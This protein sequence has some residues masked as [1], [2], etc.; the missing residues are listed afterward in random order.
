MTDPKKTIGYLTAAVFVVYALTSRIPLPCYACDSGSFWYRCIGG[1]GKGTQSCEAFKAAES[2]V[3]LASDIF[4]KAGTFLENAFDFTAVGLPDIITDFIATLKDQ[5]L[6]LKD[7]MSEKISQIINFL[8]E[9]IGL[10]LSKVKEIAVSSYDRYLKKVIDA[11]VSFTVNKLINPIVNI[12]TKIIEFR[13]LVFEKLA[14]A[15]QRFADI[16]IFGFV[17]EVVD[18]FK[19]IPQAIEGLKVNVVNMINGVKNTVIK[20]LNDGINNSAELV[21]DVVDRVS[22]LTDNI[23]DGSENIVNKVIDKIN[24]AMNGVEGAVDGITGGIETAVNN[25]VKPVVNGLSGAVNRARDVSLPL[26]IGK[27]L[28]FLPRMGTFNG[29]NIPDLDIPDISDLK[30]KDVNFSIDIPEVNI[31]APPDINPDNINFPTIPGFGFITDKIQGIK[32]SVV[33]LFERAMEPLYTGISAITILLGNVVSAIREFYN[34]YLS[35]ESIKKRA[36]LLMKQVS[37]GITTMKNFVTEEIVPSF[38]ELLKSVWTPIS[39]FVKKAAETA[40]NFLKKVGSTIGKM[41]N[42]V[43]RVVLK[44]TGVVAKGVLGTG[45]YVFGTT[46]DKFTPFLPMSLTLKVISIVAVIIW[47]F[48]GQFFKNGLD[49]FNFVYSGAT[50]A[51]VALSDLD[52]VVDA[53]VGLKL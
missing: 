4:S 50:T 41:F 28:S 47:M 30:F 7:R 19:S 25:T 3:D 9:K 38:I 17:G 29:L 32:N 2:R 39:E 1:T 53:A 10:F 40:W 13:D 8:K 6:G 43:Y 16:N 12:I 26:G 52:S 42:E 24:D 23:V 45:M 37:N 48:T 11:M 15:I 22:D 34:T 5:I 44:V 33:D 21:E 51:V 18:V 20:K 46:V 14:E 36:V 27:P 49:I 31:P 35:F